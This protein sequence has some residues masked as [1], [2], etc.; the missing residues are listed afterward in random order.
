VHQMTP[1]FLR[2]GTFL[3]RGI[4]Y[5]H[6]TLLNVDTL[7]LYEVPKATDSERTKE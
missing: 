6:P 7:T 1:I 2:T 3:D 4:D 5:F